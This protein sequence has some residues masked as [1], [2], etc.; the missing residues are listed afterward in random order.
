MRCLPYER[1]YAMAPVESI[2][3]AVA[4]GLGELAAMR[5]RPDDAARH[6]EVAMEVER[7]MRARPFLAHA[8]HEYGSMLLDHGD[9]DRA[10]ALLDDALA[11]YRELGM[12]TWAERVQALTEPARTSR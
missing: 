3:G 8:Q 5:D 2:F 12:H 7:H 9:G 10:K 1:L 4:R 6:F 11:T